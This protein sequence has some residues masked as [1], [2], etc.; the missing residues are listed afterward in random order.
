MI[1][2]YENECEMNNDGLNN[3][4]LFYNKGGL[5]L[6]EAERRAALEAYDEKFIMQD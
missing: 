1:N 6:T 5:P 2:D 4:D 3:E